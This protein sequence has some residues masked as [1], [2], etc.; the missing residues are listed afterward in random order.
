MDMETNVIE[1]VTRVDAKVKM[2]NK[3]GIFDKQS[4]V[5]DA[6]NIKCETLFEHSKRGR[7]MVV[8]THPGYHPNRFG[9]H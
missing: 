9:E 6:K 3:S 5:S 8:Q 2:Q 4:C 1:A 7:P